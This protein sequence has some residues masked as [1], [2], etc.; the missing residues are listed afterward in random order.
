MVR[1]RA[2]HKMVLTCPRRGE[3]EPSTCLQCENMQRIERREGELYV[4][5]TA[6][7]PTPKPAKP[8][9]EIPKTWI[10]IGE[11]L[12]LTPQGEIRGFSQKKGLFTRVSAQTISKI[13]PI[14]RKFAR[15]EAVNEIVKL[16]YTKKSAQ[17]Y[18]MLLAK[19]LPHLP[20]KL[21]AKPVEE[22]KPPIPKEL[23]KILAKKEEEQL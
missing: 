18:Y 16:G 9:P 17:T 22:V 12:W 15:Q 14:V 5:C 1:I 3:V 19:A 7:A 23:E 11:N 21:E 20:E 4:T 13:A 6:V 10:K 8:M 2:V